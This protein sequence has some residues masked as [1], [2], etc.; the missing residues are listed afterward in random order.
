MLIKA[1]HY[2]VT[3]LKRKI[4]IFELNKEL[5]NLLRNKIGEK[6]AQTL[7]EYI[8]VQVEERLAGKKDILATKD[9]I[10]QL[11]VELKEQKAEL[12]EM[13]DCFVRPILCRYDCVFN[14]AVLINFKLIW[15]QAL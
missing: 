10:F 15:W 5:Y 3:V 12:F 9:D 13:D 6:E 14:Q 8:S 11:R 2:I 7:T 4:A 1:I